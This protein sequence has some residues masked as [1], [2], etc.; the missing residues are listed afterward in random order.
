[1]NRIVTLYITFETYVDIVTIGPWKPWAP[2]Y[3][4]L[5][6]LMPGLFINNSLIKFFSTTLPGNRIPFIHQCNKAINF[7]LLKQINRLYR[8][9]LIV[10]IRDP[11]YYALHNTMQF[12]FLVLD[13]L[14][15][16][17][18]D[19]KREFLYKKYFARGWKFI[20]TFTK[21]DA[22]A[23]MKHKNDQTIINT[24]RTGNSGV[25]WV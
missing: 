12:K 21:T 11:D 2:L 19:T 4:G 1:M 22:T 7:N 14:P 8:K 5:F 23:I 24:L 3:N 18:T 9:V 13:C 25:H 20:Y 10:W 6:L 15:E 17:A 16:I